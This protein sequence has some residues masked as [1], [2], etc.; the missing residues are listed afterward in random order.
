MANQFGGHKKRGEVRKTC[1][2]RMWQSQM[3]LCTCW[4]VVAFS[5][6]MGEQ[7]DMGMMVGGKPRWHPANRVEQCGHPSNNYS[8]K[9]RWKAEEKQE[10][11]RAIAVR[12]LMCRQSGPFPF[13][14]PDPGAPGV[15]VPPSPV[16]PSTCSNPSPVQSMDF[17]ADWLT[18]W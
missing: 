7:R 2:T 17:T 3:Q 6:W 11:S 1:D 9:S 18:L 12:K 5:G 8:A 13:D 10:H 15:P 16:I 14:F 4:I